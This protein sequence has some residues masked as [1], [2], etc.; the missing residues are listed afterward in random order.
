[1]CV[2]VGASLTRTLIH[3]LLC[4]RYYLGTGDTEVKKDGFPAQILTG[5][6]M[7]A[8]SENK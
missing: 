4:T 8:I 5:E 3:S 2:C 6:E 1:M 7:G